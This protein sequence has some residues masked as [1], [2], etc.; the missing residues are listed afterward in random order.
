[1]PACGSPM[2]HRSPWRRIRRCARPITGRG[3]RSTVLAVTAL[4]AGYGAVGVLCNVDLTVAEGELVVV[5]GANGAGKSTLMRALS[6]LL[7]PV[8]GAIRLLDRAMEGE[9]SAGLAPRL[10]EELYDLLTAIR[11]EGT[12][13]LL[14]DQVP[15]MALSVADRAYVLQSGAIRHSDQ[16]I[17]LRHNPE[18]VRA[19]LGEATSVQW[20]ESGDGSHP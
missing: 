1:M 7:R 13:V 18:L 10:V 12:T 11:D 15:A 3:A 9:P 4:T 2:V 20:K 19:F 17:R 14:V 8:S 5:L 6:G 16:A